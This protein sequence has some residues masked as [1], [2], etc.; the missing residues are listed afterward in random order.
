MW[1]AI[2]IGFLKICSGAKEFDIAVLF[3]LIYSERSQRKKIIFVQ[4]SLF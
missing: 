2:L 4:I 1:R 3:V